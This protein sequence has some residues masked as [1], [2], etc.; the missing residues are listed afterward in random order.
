MTFERQATEP[1]FSHED[2]P[3]VN[4]V[5]RRDDQRRQRASIIP[6]RQERVFVVEDFPTS[7]DRGVERQAATK[8]RSSYLQGGSLRNGSPQR[9][10]RNSSATADAEADSSSPRQ[11]PSSPLS[12]QQRNRGSGGIVGSPRTGRRGSLSNMGSRGGWEAARDAAASDGFVG[13]VGGRGRGSSVE[14]CSR[15]EASHANSD[16]NPVYD[17]RSIVLT[18]PHCS[19]AQTRSRPTRPLHPTPTVSPLSP[20]LQARCRASRAH[21]IAPCRYGCQ[22]CSPRQNGPSRTATATAATA[23]V[24]A[25]AAAAAVAQSASSGGSGASS[26]TGCTATQ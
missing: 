21:G 26:A 16:S 3:R 13:G 12:P 7:D 17:T 9:G 14:D 6:R 10:E 11:G 4:V 22:L 8:V 24:A 2:V 15:G 18:V 20:T 25:R 1:R 19:N 5:E 23:W